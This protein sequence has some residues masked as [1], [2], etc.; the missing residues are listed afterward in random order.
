VENHEESVTSYRS[1]LLVGNLIADKGI[2]IAEM[3]KL[4]SLIGL[5]K[6]AIWADSLYFLQYNVAYF[7]V[8][9]RRISMFSGD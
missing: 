1:S 5:V 2:Q 9:S 7:L 8:I 3:S 4:G 6:H